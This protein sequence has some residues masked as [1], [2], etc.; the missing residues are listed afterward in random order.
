MEQVEMWFEKY[1]I[2]HNKTRRQIYLATDDEKV[3]R[4]VAPSSTMFPHIT[5]SCTI[6]NH[7]PTTC[8]MLYRIE[9]SVI[10][11]HASCCTLL[12]HIMPYSPYCVMCT[13]LYHI[14]PSCT[15]FNHLPTTCIMMYHMYQYETVMLAQQI[16]LLYVI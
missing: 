4:L 8:I 3:V 12:H 10:L 2:S 7:L 1:E 14:S 5:T 15:I 9:E 6:L 16:T 13:K 11:L